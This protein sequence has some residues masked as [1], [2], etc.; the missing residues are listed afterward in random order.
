MRDRVTR[1]LHVDH[2]RPNPPGCMTIWRRR[3]PQ[4]SCIVAKIAGT[5]FKM[6]IDTWTGDVTVYCKDERSMTA[7]LRA[8]TNS[9]YT[10]ITP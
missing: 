8:I 9:S 2:L 3:G 5:S 1:W 4:Y 7:V 6:T 10:M